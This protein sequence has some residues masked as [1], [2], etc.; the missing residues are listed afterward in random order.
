MTVKTTPSVDLNRELFPE[1]WY[2]VQAI[3]GR[4]A[5]ILIID[6]RK[7]FMNDICYVVIRNRLV[8]LGVLDECL[9]LYQSQTDSIVVSVDLY[10]D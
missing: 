1:P 3:H 4:S 10:K 8:R 2:E 9:Y 6:D 7:L 5:T